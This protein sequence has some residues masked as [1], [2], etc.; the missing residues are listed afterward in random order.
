MKIIVAAFILSLAY[1]RFMTA[2]ISKGDPLKAVECDPYECK[3]SNV[4]L[5]AGVC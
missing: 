5:A 1:G 4:T 2:N 3:P